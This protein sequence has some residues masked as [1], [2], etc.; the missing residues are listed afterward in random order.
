MDADDKTRRDTDDKTRR[1]TETRLLWKR[2]R[3]RPTAGTRA[4]LAS[5]YLPL[6]R[7]TVQ[8]LAARR[9]ALDEAPG[10]DP[11][12]LLGAGRLGLA[13]ALDRYDPARGVKFETYAIAVIRGAVREEIR[14]AGWAP[15]TLQDEGARIGAAR[16]L[17]DQAAGRPAS[18]A[19]LARALGVSGDA[20]AGSLARLAWW[21]PAPLDAEANDWSR[22]PEQG[23]VPG[24]AAL[25]VTLA[26]YALGADAGIEALALAAARGDA[27]RAA[28]GRLPAREAH[29]LRRWAGLDAEGDPSLAGEGESRLVIG[30][31]MGISESRA[32]QLTQQGLAR[33]RGMPDVL[34]WAPD[35]SE[36]M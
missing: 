35:S 36:N 9:A 1:D 7:L 4:A 19:Q 30:A 16:A 24:R 12:D 20:L 6:V 22:F 17:A 23:G 27:L 25:P 26:D 2:H 33:L 11:D 5:R 8:R 15:R 34:A 14:S 13:R 32:F 31:G 3:R 29:V 28:L 21:P 10:A 18:S